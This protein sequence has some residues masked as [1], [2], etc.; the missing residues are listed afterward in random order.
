MVDRYELYIY[1]FFKQS[2]Y[3][4]I[5]NK[6]TNVLIQIICQELA[7]ALK[8]PNIEMIL[9]YSN[10]V[11][12]GFLLAVEEIHWSVIHDVQLSTITIY[13]STEVCI[14]QSCFLQYHYNMLTWYKCHVMCNIL[15]ITLIIWTR[16]NQ[17]ATEFGWKFVSKMGPWIVCG[18]MV[19][20]GI[21]L[22]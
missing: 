3:C 20:W 14:Y 18:K 16:E 7:P 11:N 9:L 17:M 2:I 13:G 19:W 22:L 10:G 1:I 12:L 21:V 6:N 15:V 4:Q 8:V 5:H